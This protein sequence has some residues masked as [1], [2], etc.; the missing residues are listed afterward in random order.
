MNT[1]VDTGWV[2]EDFKLSSLKQR[3]DSDHANL[4]TIEKECIYKAEGIIEKRQ[5]AQLCK[6]LW[7][8][9]FLLY[10]Q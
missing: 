5:W 9:G 2:K 4:G 3:V 7:S 8:L 10:S 1:P 6:M